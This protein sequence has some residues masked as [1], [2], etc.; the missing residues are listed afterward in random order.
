[1]DKKVDIIGKYQQE[2]L[3]IK[4]KLT[5]LDRGR[6]YEI[7]NIKTDGYLSTNIE[8]LR[9]MLADLIYKI[10]QG[11]DSTMEKLHEALDKI[12]L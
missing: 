5:Q 9:K 7:S 2:I 6:V 8:D 1:M 10:E 12:N 3:D 4:N 11:K